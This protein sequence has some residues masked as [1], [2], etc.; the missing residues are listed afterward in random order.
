MWDSLSPFSLAVALGIIH[1]NVAAPAACRTF[2]YKNGKNVPCRPF[3][4]IKTYR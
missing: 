2:F 1:E 4:E 3:L